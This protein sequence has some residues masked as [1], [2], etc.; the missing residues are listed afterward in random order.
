MSF[1]A[2]LKGTLE[3]K[4]RDFIVVDV[5]GVGYEVSVPGS[6]LSRLGGVG[7]PVALRIFTLVREETLQL[8]GFLSNEEREAFERLLGVTGVGPRGA[9]SFLTHFSPGDLAAAVEARD[10]VAL[11]RVQ[12]IGR[13][14][15][16]RLVLELRGK[17][18]A[19]ASAGYVPA[20][21]LAFGDDAADVLLSLGY[22]AQEVATALASVP[23]IGAAAVE[24]RIKL[25]LRALD[26]LRG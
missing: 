17:L 26:T 22:T 6:T 15:A 2:S 20:P 4:G 19:T 25:G 21:D 9:L 3:E 11:T 8:F 23:P 10:A 1:I 24:E 18:S 7:E 13:K 14:T 12:G 5:G 16:D